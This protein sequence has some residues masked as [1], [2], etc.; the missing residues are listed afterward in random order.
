MKDFEVLKGVITQQNKFTNSIFLV[1]ILNTTREVTIKAS[2]FCMYVFII[3]YIIIILKTLFAKKINFTKNIRTYN[4][5]L[6][7]FIFGT[8]TAFQ[9]WYV[10]WLYSTIMWQ[11]EKM[12]NLI[13]GITISVELAKGLYFL[14]NE[15][16]IYG[17]YYYIL[18][19]A[20]TLVSTIILNKRQKRVRLGGNNDKYNQIN[21]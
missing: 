2:K 18:M 20:L 9:S 19:L 17:Q 11:K 6:L 4:N 15:W 3:I 5:L 16:F 10:M 13:L 21:A 8:I 14:L 1:L 12:I 7:I